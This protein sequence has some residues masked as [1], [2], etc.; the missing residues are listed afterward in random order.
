[1]SLIRKEMDWLSC[2]RGARAH[3]HTQ[4]LGCNATAVV[5]WGLLIVQKPICS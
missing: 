3:T 5:A 4:F 2:L 1:M